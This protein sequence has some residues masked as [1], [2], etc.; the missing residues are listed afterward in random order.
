[1]IKYILPKEIDSRT[2]EIAVKKKRNIRGYYKGKVLTIIFYIFTLKNYVFV[3]I[4][5]NGNST[6]IAEED[7]KYKNIKEE[8]PAI[9]LQIIKKYK[10][11]LKTRN[12]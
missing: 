3:S 12:K 7:I 4:F 10:D 9:S 2:L 11:V 8:Y 5:E 6:P 1:M